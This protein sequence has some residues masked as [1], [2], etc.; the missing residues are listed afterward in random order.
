MPNTLILFASSREFGNTRIIAE[1]IR[2][3]T[4]ADL[5]YINNLDLSYYDYEHR[6]S[7]R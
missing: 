4:D 5:L 6:K 2:T 3:R 1:E 7:G